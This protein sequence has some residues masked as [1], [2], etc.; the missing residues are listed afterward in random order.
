[1]GMKKIGQLL[2]FMAFIFLAACGSNQ[3]N[4][5]SEAGEKGPDH[6]IR[7]VHEE[8]IDSVQQSYVEE[9]KKIIEEKSDGNVHVEIYPVGQL[10]ECNDTGRA[11]A[12]RG[13]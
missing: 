5:V 8:Q 1:M 11:I 10:G 7:F 3:G 12:N 13:R 9:F 6:V 2:L 4:T